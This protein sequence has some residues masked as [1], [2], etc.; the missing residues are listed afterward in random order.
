VDNTATVSRWWLFDPVVYVAIGQ[1]GIGEY[2]LAP[3]SNFENCLWQRGPYYDI[4]STNSEKQW[5][6]WNNVVSHVSTMG[7]LDSLFKEIGITLFDNAHLATPIT[8][9]NKLKKAHSKR[10]QLQSV[11]SNGDKKMFERHFQF[12]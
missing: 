9:R 1:F 5:R 12:V 11:K 6:T 8:L 4:D 2:C 3:A 10:A 7:A